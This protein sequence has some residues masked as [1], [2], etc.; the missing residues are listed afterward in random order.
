V[1]CQKG[2]WKRGNSCKRLQTELCYVQTKSQVPIPSVSFAEEETI[3]KPTVN[4]DKR[5]AKADYL[6]L[7]TW[8]EANFSH[9]KL[10]RA[11][12]REGK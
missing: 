5:K 10:L 4:C 11:I 3:N 6:N 9:K 8:E 2:T 1:T 7:P 12:K